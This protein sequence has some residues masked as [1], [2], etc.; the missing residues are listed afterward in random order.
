MHITGGDLPGL[1]AL[2]ERMLN[3]NKSVLVG[4]PAGEMNNVWDAIGIGL[5]AFRKVRI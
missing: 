3:A 1:A 5:F 4:V 2:R